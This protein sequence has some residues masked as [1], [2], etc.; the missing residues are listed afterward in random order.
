MYNHE[1]LNAIII[2][3]SEEIRLIIRIIL[4]KDLEISYI[5]IFCGAVF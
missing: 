2:R 5:I 4:T 3:N 1:V